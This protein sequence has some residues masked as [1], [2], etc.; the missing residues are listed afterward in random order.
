[1]D[2]RLAE[3]RRDG[4]VIRYCVGEH[5]RADGPYS[6]VLNNG[7]GAVKGR[8]RANKRVGEWRYF[9]PKSR[10]VRIEQ[11]QA[12]ELATA[13]DVQEPELRALRCGKFDIFTEPPELPDLSQG[14]SESPGSNATTRAIRWYPPRSARKR[15]QAGKYKLGQRQGIWKYWYPN[16][17]L[18][19]RGR[20]ERGR[21]VGRWVLW[22]RSG[23]RTGLGY[24]KGGRLVSGTHVLS[25][26]AS[27]R[28]LFS[29]SP[30]ELSDSEVR[31][32]QLQAR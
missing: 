9:A 13:R 32:A 1:M 6:C 31:K 29:K 7:A 15:W 28:G 23:E 5:G 12:G 10:L 16:G 24:Y 3:N 25:R 18:R 11:W 4:A 21:P 30:R 20:F 14:W 27:S 19:G 2:R 8:F 26:L 22:N 17:Q